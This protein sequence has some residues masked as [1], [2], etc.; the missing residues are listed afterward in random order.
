MKLN[1]IYWKCI[2]DAS[3]EKM[4]DVIGSMFIREDD[5]TYVFSAG[6]NEAK[7]SKILETCIRDTMLEFIAP[8]TKTNDKFIVIS[9][10][11]PKDN[12]LL[13]F[14]NGAYFPKKL[15]MLVNEKPDI[16]YFLREKDICIDMTSLNRIFMQFFNKM[17]N[18]RRSIVR[19]LGDGFTNV[20]FL[21]HSHLDCY[22]LFKIVKHL[23]GNS[24]CTNVWKEKMS[25]QKQHLVAV[26]ELIARYVQ[27]K[28]EM[29][30]SI[31]LKEY[32]REIRD[33]LR[34]KIGV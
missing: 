26:N 3:I 31:E 34:E 7:M 4:F 19:F 13:K 29:N 28:N 20:I 24:N 5:G 22:A 33:Y 15:E 32:A 27:K 6:W 25:G 16:K 2:L 17:F 12:M 21:S 8:S 18:D 1:L 30:K 14:K 9:S 23:Y 11:W 10:C